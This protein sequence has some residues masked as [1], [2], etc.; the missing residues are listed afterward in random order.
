[1]STLS[2]LIEFEAK[3]F[4]LY[5]FMFNGFNINFFGNAMDENLNPKVEVKGSSPCSCRL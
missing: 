5:N 3:K 2:G 1:M 4:D